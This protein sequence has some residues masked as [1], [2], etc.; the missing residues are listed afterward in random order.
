MDNQLRRIIN[1]YPG[2]AGYDWQII[3]S[4]RTK[5][6]RERQLEF[7]APDERYNP[8]PLKPTI[9]IFNPDLQGET[10]DTAV[11]GDML[12]Y[13]PMVDRNFA[14]LR[15]AFRQTLT[16]EQLAVDRN[17]YRRAVQKHGENRPFNDWFERSRLDAYLRGYLTPDEQ[18]NW[19]GVYT[20]EQVAILEM[21]KDNLK[22][23]RKND[24]TKKVFQER[25]ERGG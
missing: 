20:P 4:R 18:D 23:P 10:L 17:A 6:N 22:T 24:K 3:D 13:L 14:S 12:H 2:L 11:I 9:E 25:L 8:R 1:K 21:M 7:Y 15:E 19:R 5:P 16:S